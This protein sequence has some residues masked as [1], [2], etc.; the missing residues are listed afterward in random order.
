[1]NPNLRHITG[2]L[3][4][5]VRNVLESQGFK[6]INNYLYSKNDELVKCRYSGVAITVYNL[7]FH[8]LDGGKVIIFFDGS[9]PQ[10]LA[11]FYEEFP[12]R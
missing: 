11:D 4:P 12:E 6:F 9:N 1:M 10:V 8:I 7:C 3:H 5:L 2:I